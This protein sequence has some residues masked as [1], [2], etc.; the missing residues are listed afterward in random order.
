MK[1]KLS[2][3]PVFVTLA[4]SLTAQVPAWGIG[5]FVRPD[6]VN[7]IIAPDTN[8][9][10]ACPMRGAPI[11]WEGLHTFNPAAVVKD[12][13]IYVLYRAE[14][15][16][17]VTAIGAHTSRLGLA[18]SDDGLHF[19]RLPQPDLFPANDGQKDNEWTGGCEDP[20]LVESEDGT[21]VVMYTQW[22]HKTARLAVAT[23]RDLTHWTKYGPVFP[24]REGSSKS[25]AI[26]CQL[27]DGRMKAVKIGG[28]YRMYWGEGAIFCAS[29]EDLIHWDAG[30]P[31]MRT[32]EHKFDSSLV[33]AGP[34]PVLT[35]HGIVML[36][37]G[38]NDSVVGDL[39]LPPDT[40]AAG[41]A[42][43][44]ARNPNQLLARAEG[45]F[46]QPEAAFERSGQYAAG[47]TFIEGLVS[48]HKQWFLYY[49]C[50]DSYVAVA[51][52]PTR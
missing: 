38:K 3:L 45:P 40:Y 37:N 21:F 41:Q 4:T 25:G 23:S 11:H 27:V 1:D 20:R 36:Y 32:R 16:T 15:D 8:S 42:L 34:P 35:D 48:F 9:V 26:V 10:F 50:A 30:Q 17:G 6:G 22:N 46:Y 29:S 52:C 13:R 39:G 7:P 28:K 49:G 19:R 5:P 43:F 44:D 2:L 31:V 18:V 51:V 12:D 14:D 24:N 47:T 33:E